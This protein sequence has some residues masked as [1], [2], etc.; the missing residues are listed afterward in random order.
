MNGEMNIIN[1]DEKDYYNKLFKVCV[2]KGYGYV[3][4]EYYVYCNDDMES[5]LEKVVAY[6][7][8]E[9]KEILLDVDDI[10]RSIDDEFA[11]E[12]VEY[13]KDNPYGD[14]DTFIS[15][16]LELMYVDATMEGAEDC[17]YIRTENLRIEE[18]EEY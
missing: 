8:K 6:A 2:W 17:W 7:E 11:S 4:N 10:T 3:L 12:L 1:P 5:L 16:Y 13:L 18:V 14:A 15:D 9:D